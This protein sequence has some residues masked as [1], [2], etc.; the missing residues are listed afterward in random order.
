MKLSW[1]DLE[2]RKYL[3]FY[4]D[5]FYAKGGFEDYVGHF[6]SVQ[7]CVDFVTSPENSDGDCWMHVV[8]NEKIIYSGKSEFCYKSDLIL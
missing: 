3:L 4:G 1:A 2:N 7:D 5:N 6:D 8:L